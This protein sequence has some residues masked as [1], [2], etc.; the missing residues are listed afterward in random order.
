MKGWKPDGSDFNFVSGGFKCAVGINGD[1]DGKLGLYM[2]KQKT[3]GG[4]TEDFQDWELVHA[5]EYVEQMAVTK[6]KGDLVTMMNDFGKEAAPKLKTMTGGQLPPLPA[7]IVGK[8]YWH[9][10][11]KLAFRPDTFEVFHQG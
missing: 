1:T 11:Y 4:A 6:Y 5:W 10:R 2:V 7:D 9:V 3:A 8:L